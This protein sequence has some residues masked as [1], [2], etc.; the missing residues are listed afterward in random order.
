[1]LISSLNRIDTFVKKTAATIERAGFEA[2]SSSNVYRT[3]LGLRV[4]DIKGF[5]TQSIKAMSSNSNT[6]S[7]TSSTPV[8]Q[9]WATAVEQWLTLSSSP[10]AAAPSMGQQ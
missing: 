8:G 2:S 1:M 10:P 6:T 5:E 4:R 3:V 7:N 9:A